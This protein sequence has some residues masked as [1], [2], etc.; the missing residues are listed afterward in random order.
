MNRI[1]DHGGKYSCHTNHIITL[2][3]NKQTKANK[4]KS[5]TLLKVSMRKKKCIACEKITKAFSEL[6]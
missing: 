1:K 4:K 3:V 2:Y 5:R 6:Q